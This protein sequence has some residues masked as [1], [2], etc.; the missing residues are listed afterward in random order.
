VTYLGREVEA[1][2]AASKTVLNKKRHLLGQVQLYRAGQVGSLAEV[3][4]VLKGEGQG[5]GFGEGNGDVLVGLF[6]IGV[7]ADSNG[8]VTNVTGARELDALLAGLDYD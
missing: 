7:L 2:V 5:D 1:Q 8:A 4:K 3:D 6:D